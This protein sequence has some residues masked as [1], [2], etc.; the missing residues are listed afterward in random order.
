MR[1]SGV[2]RDVG[3]NIELALTLDNWHLYRGKLHPRTEALKRQCH[4]FADVGNNDFLV[5]F[6]FPGNG[7]SPK[8][9]M[10]I[11]RSLLVSTGGALRT[12]VTSGFKE[13]SS[14]TVTLHDSFDVWKLI[15]T[16]LYR[17]PVDMRDVTTETV[18][19]AHRY[20]LVELFCACFL[21]IEVSGI[22]KGKDLVEDWLEVV[23]LVQPPRAFCEYFAL[24]FSLSFDS[25]V[26]KLEKCNWKEG[27]QNIWV[28][29]FSKGMFAACVK[30]IT[31]TS[32][33]DYT[34][35][36]LDALFTDVER[37]ASDEQIKHVLDFF[38]WRSA[39]FNNA[40]SSVA[41]LKWS[42]RSWR[43]LALN[44]Q[45]TAAK[46]SFDMR[47]RCRVPIR[48]LRDNCVCTYK[49]RYLSSNDEVGTVNASIRVV[50]LI[51]HH[52]ELDERGDLGPMMVTVRI[53]SKHRNV[54]AYYVTGN[55]FLIRE[56]CACRVSEHKDFKFM[57]GEDSFCDRMHKFKYGI[58]VTF[59]MVEELT[60]ENAHSCE[61]CMWVVGVRMRF[62][63]I[64][65][66][67]DPTS[68]WKGCEEP[69]E[70]EFSELPEMR[71]HRTVVSRGKY[72]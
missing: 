28:S 57:E 61:K 13:C 39:S 6:E 22:W 40:L 23:S 12:L 31:R 44:S 27:T 8:K 29:F 33:K 10:Y 26:K 65:K 17:Q 68:H 36:L 5:T 46:S 49:G 3:G 37:E 35:I 19:V 1:N 66:A 38:D 32:A 52:D 30:Y 54:R 4:L 20:E 62:T 56:P 9:E 71:A 60:R 7:G 50:Y 45:K 55:V 47:V 59:M 24:Q 34:F 70:F 11:H 69:D 25:V 15:R 18:M 43:A 48:I 51:V 63:R 14:K 58:S 2:L 16:Y 41:A 53:N 64:E 21:W 72:P 42:P 67:S